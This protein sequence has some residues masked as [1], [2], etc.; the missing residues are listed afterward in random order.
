MID[1]GH[2]VQLHFCKI[3]RLKIKEKN[4]YRYLH[5]RFLLNQILQ[6]LHSRIPFTIL[7]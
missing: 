5:R 2:L 4:A 1:N 7:S 6:N 3:V